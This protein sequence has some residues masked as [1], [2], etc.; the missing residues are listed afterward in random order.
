MPRWGRSWFLLRRACTAVPSFL[1][2]WAA[3]GCSGSQDREPK[4]VPCSAGEGTTVFDP[5]RHEVC[6]TKCFDALDCPRGSICAKDEEDATNGFCAIPSTLFQTSQRALLDGF[7]VAEMPAALMVGDV[8]ELQW[9]RPAGA[10]LVNCAL[11]TCPPAFRVPG[12]SDEW[13]VPYDPAKVVIANYDHCAIASEV[14]SEPEGAFNLRERDNE[15]KPPPEWVAE[16][17]PVPEDECPT[18]EAATSL[19]HG[20]APVTELLV[21]CWA[22]DDT[23]IV[24]ATQ[25]YEVDAREIYNYKNLFAPQGECVHTDPEGRPETAHEYRVCTYDADAVDPRLGICASDAPGGEPACHL[26]C[27]SDCDCMQTPPLNGCRTLR[28]VHVRGVCAGDTS[29]ACVD[30]V[31]PETTADGA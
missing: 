24:A 18:P 31:P 25:L 20:C 9:T 29:G 16:H 7:D 26:P 11:L 21:G 12:G 5:Y 27:L 14:S 15:H 30:V 17:E 4:Q 23:T 10:K 2:S 8:Y 1:A 6:P 3:L 19:S 13:L 28:D 22:Y